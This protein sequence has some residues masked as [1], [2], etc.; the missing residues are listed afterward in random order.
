MADF[1]SFYNRDK[2][3]YYNVKDSEARNQID[4]MQYKITCVMY[5]NAMVSDPA[6]NIFLIDSRASVYLG[7]FSPEAETACIRVIFE[8]SM[9]VDPTSFDNF[10][11]N[12]NGTNR[13]YPIYIN[14]HRDDAIGRV[15]AGSVLDFI[16]QKT[17]V[18][19][20]NIP[21]GYFL[22]VNAQAGGDLSNYYTKTE[23]DT[24]LDG[25]VDKVAGKGLST[26]DYTTAEQ[27]KLASI[28]SGAE[29]NV[30]TDWNQSDATADDYLKNKPSIPTKVS[31]LTNDTGFIT[32]TVNNLTNY[33]LKSDSYTKNEV[34]ALIAGISTLHVE[35][36]QTLPSSNISTTT[37]YL[38]PKSTAQTENVYDEYINLDGTSAGWEK[39]GD[40]TITVPTDADDISYDNTTSGLSA[41]NVQ[42]ALDEVVDDLDNKADTSSLAAVATSGSYA[43]LTNTPTIPAAQVNSDWNAA[44]GV[45]QILN[46]PSIPSALADLSDDNTHRVVTD[47]EKSTWSGKV[48]D[49]PTFTEA[50]TRA[51]IASGESFTTILGKIKK[52]FTDLK[53]V[54]FTGSYN[55]LTDQPT[56]PAAQVNSDWNASSGVAQILNKPTIP[57][58]TWRP[59]MLQ[60]G[61]AVTQVIG[62]NDSSTLVIKKGTNISFT[63]AIAGDGSFTIN[64]TDTK[65]SDFFD[66]YSTELPNKSS[67]S[68]STTW[69]EFGK[70][71]IT[72]GYWIITVAILYPKKAGGGRSV[73][74]VCNTSNTETTTAPGGSTSQT[75]G[76]SGADVETNVVLTTTVN[77]TANGYIHIMGRQ[78]SGGTISG[79][80][81]IRARG[82]KLM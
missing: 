47:T 14:S 11:Y 79:T 15:K 51:N 54:A 39:I 2:D 42:D 27:T 82:I 69:S 66:Y 23:A 45:A 21:M 1:S 18:A 44:S 43:D 64:A 28:A 35:V 30:Q 55:D 26:E 77:V 62:A 80:H 3:E 6:R 33:Y 22:M 78:N 46:K 41:S 32:N 36:V 70:F 65:P 17:G 68:S 57:T 50:S 20:G 49:N 31:D 34:N 40:T 53:T 74:L 7:Q 58:V 76:S 75:V 5:V 13:Y 60:D 9:V 81:Y 63:D 4:R 24:L 10:G 48:G 12:V 16:W 52:F 61:S 59:V 67:S 8:S 72:K 29:A 73:G 38:V 56:I 37:I 25:K 71:S 19:P